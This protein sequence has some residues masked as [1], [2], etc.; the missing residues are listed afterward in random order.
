[1]TVFG[2]VRPAGDTIVAVTVGKVPPDLSP[3]A[4][5]LHYITRP[6]HT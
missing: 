5:G 4:W 2:R 1:M 3:A 6:L